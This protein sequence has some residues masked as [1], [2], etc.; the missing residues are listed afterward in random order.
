MTLNPQAKA[1]LDRM[2]ALN[3]PEAWDL[4][5]KARY[6]GHEE[7]DMAGPIEGGVRIDHRF[8]SS[9]TADLPIRIYTPEGPGPFNAFIYYHGGGW[10]FGHIDRY[11]AQLVSLAKKTN[12][13]VVS[14]NYQKSPEHKFPIPHDDCYETLEWVAA[15]GAYLN[16]NVNKIGVGG[17]SAGGNLASGVALRA[18]DEGKIKLAYQLLIYPANGLDFEAPSY[19]NNAEGYGLSRRGMIWFWEQY[20]NE[21]DKNNPYALPHTAK[22]LAGLAPIVIITAE[23]DVL[24]DDGLLYAKKLK[25]AGNYV[26][27]KDYEGHIHGFFSHGKYVDEGIAVRDFFATEINKIL[28]S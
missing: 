15:N 26:V 5:A 16:I 13:V 28:A 3:L 23:Y 9:A 4:G 17:D 21:K 12:S 22:S 19:I 11:D 8:I 24:R 7:V 2:K 25:E 10:V 27:H 6:G 1:F 20:L 18:R 14:V